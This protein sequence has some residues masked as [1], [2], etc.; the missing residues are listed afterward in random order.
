MVGERPGH[1]LFLSHYFP[2]EGNAPASR[3]YE[4]CKRWVR[5]GHRVTVITS[6]PNHPNGVVY[7]GY[8]N[9]LFQSENVGGVHVM[10]VWTYLAA[11]KGTVRRI[12]NYLS[13][14][15]SATLAGILAS[16]PDV[17]IA[18]SPQFFCGWAGTLVSTLRRIPFILEIRD[19][20]PESISAV[21]A[22]KTGLLLRALECLEHSMY[23][24][25]KHIVTVG[26]GYKKL[27]CDRGVPAGK[28]SV[29][30]NGV[31]R[32]L[33]V[34]VAR[35]E[36]LRERHGLGGSHVCAYVGTIG[37]ACGLEVVIRAG[38]ILREKGR[39]DISFL[40]VG[41]GAVREKLEA[42]ARQAELGNVAFAG[43]QDKSLMPVYLASVDS[44]LVH[45]RRQDLFKSVLP[46]K[47][48][49]A[50]AMGKPVVL[51]V[52]GC[53][54]ELLNRAGG[55]ITIEPDNAEQLVAAVEKLADD[56]VMAKRLGAAGRAYVLERFDRDDLSAEYLRIIRE[57]TRRSWP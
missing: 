7:P 2:P 27:L 6:V 4:I 55:G 30:T 9:R 32:E 46:S 8:R 35:D 3:V 16:R 54:A 53:A 42:Q 48:F 17:L 47:L 28:I 38:Q 21:G 1:I 33:F 44:C 34:P 10:R 11:N 23:Q 36:G 45:L 40:L 50:A 14:M 52:E 12:A 57:T 29:V 22:M 51:G 18:T 26:D 19:I 5:A 39:R 43:R 20:W 24:S 13:Y 56:P 37:M 41:D 15:A 25:A 49:E 31:D